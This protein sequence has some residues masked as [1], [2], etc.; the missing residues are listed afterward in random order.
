MRL[1]LNVQIVWSSEEI[2]TLPYPF[3]SAS[4]SLM[5]ARTAEFGSTGL[6]HV[7]S[8]PACTFEVPVTSP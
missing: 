1:K 5:R 4:L 7:I 8:I 6:T 3:F 2:H